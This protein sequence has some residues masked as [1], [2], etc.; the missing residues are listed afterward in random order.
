MAS[1]SSSQSTGRLEAEPKSAPGVPEVKPTNGADVDNG[2]TQHESGIGKKMIG[3]AVLLTLLIVGG[4][5]GIHYWQYSSVH[6]STDD[7]YLTS[8]VVEI[9][10]QVAGSIVDLPVKENQHV[11]KGDL[12]ARLDDATYQADLEQAKAN[13]ASARAAVAASGLSVGLTQ[14]T[15][16]AQILQARGGVAQT[17]RAISGAQADL[18]RIAA[19]IRSA[20]AQASGAQANIRSA[21]AAAEAAVAARD[22]AVASVRGAQAS[23]ITA[24]AGVKTA[25]ANLAQAQA[26]YDKANKDALRYAVLYDEDAVSA[27]TLD[28]ANAAA[29]AARAQVEG[30]QR[31]IEQAQST[32]EARRADVAAAQEQVRASDATIQQTQAMTVAA[33]EAANAAVANVSQTQAQLQTGREAVGQQV[34][35]REQA[36]GVLNQA[37]TAPKQVAVSEAS[38]TTSRTRIAQA[39]AALKSAQ[40]AVNRTRLVAP[41]DGII[42][43]KTGEI[44]QQLAVGQQVM[45]LVPDGDIWVTANFKETQLKRVRPGQEAE[46]EVDALTGEK[47]K[48]RVESISAGT[49]S[50]FALLPSDNATG[51][52]TKVV[53]RVPVKIVFDKNQK[54]IEELRAGLSVVASIT[55]GK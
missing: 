38:V 33:R 43:K 26:N 22:R 46:I 23:V 34:A 18:K 2:D 5:W 27:Q 3:L 19:S 11:K 55:I 1:P 53:Q 44:G 13:L 48:G 54:G 50:T 20:Q 37:Q 32:V 41:F 39:E 30:L 16:T 52:F 12:L 8:D 17:D 36:V 49:G 45:A 24:E 4:I 6:V 25:Q 40:I 29:K 9:T 28:T 35:R 15:G 47:F 7:A 42:S 51:N 10:P 21:Q 31:Q 14:A